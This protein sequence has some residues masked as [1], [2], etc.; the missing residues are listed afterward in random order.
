MLRK[1][2]LVFGIVS[3]LLYIAMLFTVAMQW[4]ASSIKRPF[5]NLQL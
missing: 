3:S 5:S 2:F 1:T 4:N